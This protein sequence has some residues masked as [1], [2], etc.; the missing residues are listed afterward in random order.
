[1]GVPE[2]AQTL[3]VADVR[4]VRIALLVGVRVV[5]AVVGDPVE[6]AALERHRADDREAVLDRLVGLER[7]MRQQPVI[8][9]R[10]PEAVQQ[11]EPGHDAEVDPV[12]PALPQQD[13]CS[14]QPEER[15]DHPDHVRDA[16]SPGHALQVDAHRVSVLVDVARVQRTKFVTKL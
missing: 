4:G 13:D 12:D 11:V 16:F 15:D 10:D 8:A 14:D 1:V 3:A 9:D 7:A 2:A 5:L 6:H